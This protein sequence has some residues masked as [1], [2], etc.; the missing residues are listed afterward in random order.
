MLAFQAPDLNATS[1]LRVVDGFLS[2][3]N[4]EGVERVSLQSVIAMG[5]PW[6][7]PQGSQR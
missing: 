2:S 3:V 4:R 7:L 6:A 1:L 5:S